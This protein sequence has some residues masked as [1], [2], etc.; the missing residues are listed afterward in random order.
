MDGGQYVALIE[1]LHEHMRIMEILD[2]GALD[3][4]AQ[5]A[6]ASAPARGAPLASSRETPRRLTLATHIR[7]VI[8]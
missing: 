2:F 4:G 5:S 1:W 3:F 8:T 6:I 7:S